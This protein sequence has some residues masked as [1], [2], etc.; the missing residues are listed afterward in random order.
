MDRITPGIVA[1][2]LGAFAGVALFVP[3]VA[4]SYRR[5]GRL[6][7]GRLLLWAAALMYF[8]AIWAYTLVPLPDT[9]TYRCAGVNLDPLTFVRDIRGAFDGVGSPL[10]DPALLQL[11][12]NVLLFVPLGFFLR[13]LGGRGIVVALLTGFAL[14]LL[15][16]TTQLTGVWGVFP[17]AYRVFDVVDL[18]TNTLGA[19]LGAVLALAVPRTLRGSPPAPDADQPRPVTR[20]RRLLAMVCDVLVYLFIGAAVSVATQ[21]WLQFVIGDTDAVG[22]GAI[23][24]VV[25]QG[26]AVGAVLTVILMTGRSFGDLAVQLRYVGDRLPTWAERTLRAVGG[27]AGF[28]ALD[29]LTRENG[30]WALLFAVIAVVLALTT[31]DGRGLPGLISGQTL[32]DA[33]GTRAPR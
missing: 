12:L 24:S 6:S 7:A 10:A 3:F 5:R 31:R 20:R 21:L 18:A 1:V 4:I 33:R 22:E 11:G 23:A 8:W 26:V 14:S 9:T 27:I 15:V 19:G 28:A 32:T 29:S 17:C 16:E 25:G 13:V 2:L 30:A